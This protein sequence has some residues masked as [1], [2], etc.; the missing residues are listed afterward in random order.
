MLP[1]VRFAL[2]LIPIEAEV[3][4]NYDIFTS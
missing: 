3:L 1:F 2:R 4:H